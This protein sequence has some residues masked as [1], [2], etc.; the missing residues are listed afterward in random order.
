MTVL[1]KIKSLFKRGKPGAKITEEKSPEVPEEKP[2]KE[3]LRVA[4]KAPPK[5]TQPRKRAPQADKKPGGAKKRRRR[6]RAR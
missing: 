5:T 4:T 1:D 2:G 3:E 6:K